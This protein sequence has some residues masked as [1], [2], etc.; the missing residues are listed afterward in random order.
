MPRKTILDAVHETAKGLHK[1]GAWI[2][3]HI[4]RDFDALCLPP[5][6]HESAGQL[7]KLPLG[8]K[9]SQAVFAGYLNTSP[10]S[11]QKWEQG[12]K[13]P[14]GPSLKLL[15]IIDQKDFVEP[16]RPRAAGCRSATANSPGQ[17]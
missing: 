3:D 11:E 13:Q 6:K 4:A 16:G 9:A 8:Y 10:S 14:N 12:K 15:D 2:C 5:V 7:K 17:L 1:A